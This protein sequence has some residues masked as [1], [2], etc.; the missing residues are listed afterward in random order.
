MMIAVSVVTYGLIT[1]I[2]RCINQV[3]CSMLFLQL[4]FIGV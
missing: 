4:H 3:L 2:I 1:T